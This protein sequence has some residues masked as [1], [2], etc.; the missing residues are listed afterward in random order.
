MRTCAQ[1]AGRYYYNKLH[2]GQFLIDLEPLDSQSFDRLADDVHD[3]KAYYHVNFKAKLL[4]RNSLPL[5]FFAE[6]E[7]TD[8]PKQVN[9]CV[10]LSCSGN[11]HKCS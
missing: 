9:M 6:L 11:A 3:K 4:T 10:E 8:G 2:P 1:M 5:L 7:G